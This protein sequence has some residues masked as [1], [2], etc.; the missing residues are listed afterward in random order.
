MNCS[1]HRREGLGVWVMREALQVHGRHGVRHGAG[2]CGDAVDARTLL[3][4][5]GRAPPGAE[6]AAGH[7]QHLRAVHPEP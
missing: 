1:Q 3:G 6:V 2:R 7:L 4:R 5:P